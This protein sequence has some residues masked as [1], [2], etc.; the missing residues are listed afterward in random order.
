MKPGKRARKIEAEKE[1]LQRLLKA[2]QRD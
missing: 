1:G 2:Y